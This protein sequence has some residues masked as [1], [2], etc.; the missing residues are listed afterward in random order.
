M[1]VRARWRW[2]LAMAGTALAP[3]CQVDR[4]T[5]PE[6]L[7]EPAVGLAVSDVS[8]PPGAE[9]AVLVRPPADGPALAGIQGRVRFDPARL[10]YVGQ[11]LRG[12]TLVLASHRDL[13]RGELVF[14]AFNEAGIAADDITFVF[15]AR[16]RG[17]VSALALEIEETVAPGRLMPAGV[18]GSPTVGDLRGAWVPRGAR[19]LVLADWIDHLGL[20]EDAPAGRA[21]LRQAPGEGFVYGD[22]TLNGAVT[23]LD[24]AFTANLSLGNYPLLT[25]ATKDLVV[26]A[27]VAPANL[28]GLGEPEDPVPPGR[29]ADGTLAITVLD[30][31]AIRNES[32]QQNVPIVGDPIPGRVPATERVVVTGTI[33][34]GTTR[35]FTRDTTY[36]LQGAVQVAGM[37]EI[38]AGTRIEGD[39]ATRGALV[40]RRG[41]NLI[42][43]GTRL[44]PVIFT[45]NAMVKSRGCWGGIEILGFSILNNAE[46]TSG[47]D[48]TGCPEKIA[49][50]SGA[51]YGGCAPHD[52]S[53]ALRYM[54]V[55]FGGM[56][57]SG[58][59]P[60]PGLALFGVGLGTRIDS[61]QVFGSAGEGIL[62]SGGQVNLRN[63]VMSNNAGTG[64]RWDD[65]WGGKGQFL[66]IQHDIGDG[67]LLHGSNFAGNPNATP[68]A[69]PT[70]YN[71]TLVGP[72]SSVGSAEGLVLEHGTDV[73]VRNALV[74]RPGSAGMD[75]DGAETC[76]RAIASGI[77]LENSVFFAGAPDLSTDADCL[78]EVA[79]T[80]DPAR[81][82]RLLDPLLV[83]P[84]GTLSPDFRPTPGSPLLTDFATPPADGFFDPSATYLGAVGPLTGVGN[85]IP[86]Y[87]GWIRGWDGAP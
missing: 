37:L 58:G 60:V 21:A 36:E 43:T 10:A 57:P 34:I 59:S 25:D 87:P 19:Q 78:D 66:I 62:V 71:L 2:L 65:G 54:R 44:Q 51:V 64:L 76:A 80:T 55:E 6:P 56:A 14:V 26:A 11:P 83:E 3:A 74:L 48:I 67:D 31:A 70:L 9:V 68:R 29:N 12:R 27:N 22:V 30:V 32:L 77:R 82:N 73:L 61:V 85:V 16:A 20:A 79:Y 69:T 17:L 46:S 38:Q 28:P 8:A 13:E 45:C 81:H 72:G 24:A 53:G 39:A 7:A 1:P 15:Q 47:D 63:V 18:S 4:P 50:G 40:I 33:G 86:W 41:G 5:R 49:M 75:V 35:T 23:A 84:Y 52:T 42:V